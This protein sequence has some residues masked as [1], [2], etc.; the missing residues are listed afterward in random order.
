[1]RSS[2]RLPGWF[3]SLTIACLLCLPSA[4]V[5]WAP[6]LFA[7]DPSRVDDLTVNTDPGGGVRAT[8]TIV[9]PAKPE[10]LQAILTDYPHWPELFE[11][12]MRMARIERNGDRT[13]T[14]IV[15]DHT[16]LP[17][18]RRLLSESYA[19]SD[20]GLITDLRGGD[21]KRYHRV[22]KL[23]NEAGGS[24]TRAEFELIVD[25][26]TILPNW[27]VALA[28]RRELE[29]HFRIVREKALQKARSGS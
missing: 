22:W 24:Q 13:I 7:A 12:R 8:A 28:M 10:V 26:D 25:I 19:P 23:R 3:T 11:T 4:A 20:G 14:E 5:L 27:L 2:D 29:S 18:E 15:I 6:Q 9:F 17:G 16:L 21:F 1:M